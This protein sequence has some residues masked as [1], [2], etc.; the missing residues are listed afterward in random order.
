[1]G[2]ALRYILIG[3]LALQA[4]G[5]GVAAD[6]EEIVTRNENCVVVIV[7][8]RGSTGAEVQSSGCVIHSDGY[9]LTTAHQI[10]GVGGFTGRL[11]DGTTFPLEAVMALQEKELAL[12][13]KQKPKLTT[14]AYYTK[15]EKI[16]LELAMLYSTKPTKPSHKKDSHVN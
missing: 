10:V 14:G 7:G 2:K 16:A 12:L 1:M 5:L 9:V 15:L 11:A 13:R 6:I 8:K 4:P 3:A